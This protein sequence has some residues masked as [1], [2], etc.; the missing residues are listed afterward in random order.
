MNNY[1]NLGGN[2]DHIRPKHTTSMFGIFYFIDTTHEANK[3]TCFASIFMSI[4][5]GK[6]NES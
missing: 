1:L 5:G 2:A 4:L 3:K 6:I